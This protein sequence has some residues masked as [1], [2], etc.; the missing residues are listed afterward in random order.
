MACISKQEDWGSL[1]YRLYKE[2]A[3]L[4]NIHISFTI[5]LEER[6]YVFSHICFILV[7]LL[8]NLLSLSIMAFRCMVQP[9]HVN[10]TRSYFKPYIHG[11]DGGL[12]TSKQCEKFFD[13]IVL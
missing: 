5:S 1:I 7:L 12:E 8:D 11:L 9:R 6:Q 2:A 13:I 4:T 10:F 3:Y